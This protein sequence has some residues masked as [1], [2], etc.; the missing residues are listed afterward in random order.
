MRMAA[1]GG[2]L[3]LAPQVCAEGE[4]PV[5]PVQ[6]AQASAPQA[7]ASPVIRPGG[8]Q[9]AAPKEKSGIQNRVNPRRRKGKD[10]SEE[11]RIDADQARELYI[12]RKLR[13]EQIQAQQKELSNNKRTLAANRARMQ[14]RLIET[15]RA[16]R[17][18]E[19]RLTEIEERLAS[20][21]AKVREQREKLDDKSAQ[22][23][24]L[25]VLMQGMSRQPPPLMITHSRDA[26][27]MIRSGMVVA[28]FY[29][30]IEKLATQIA[31]EVSQL[32]ASEKEAELQEQRRKSEQVQNSRL[33]A[34]IDL[35]LIENREQLEA[36]S[37]RADSLSSATKINIASI[38]SLEEM[39]PAL[40]LERA[41]KTN[42]ASQDFGK[43][44]GTEEISPN[45]AK[46]VMIEPGRM[47]PAIPFSNSQGLLPMPAQGKMLIR[48]GQL[49]RD[50]AA[51][52]GVHIETRPAAQIISPCDG[53][54]LYAGPFR[55]Y[56][57]LL[58]IDPGG[59]YHVVVAGMDRIEATK[60]QFVLAGEPVAAMGTETRS[61]DKTP[62]RPIL[63]VEFR[64]D[65]Q[66]ID[67][68]PWWS[69]GGKG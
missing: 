19:K 41:R 25:F 53:L 39:L 56:G 35:L 46:I 18:S 22:M 49:D 61:G 43:M 54:I 45:A 12:R 65:Q 24:A 42:A 38:K 40:D 69:A 52:K 5:K 4:F 60:G 63:Y 7:S 48:F 67:P 15:A 68:A 6:L 21:R 58:I 2:L 8:Q 37:A 1:A 29:G 14:A 9:K 50:G 64:R 3:L 17:L 62:A 66:S 26:L 10:G 20:T 59:G 23:S 28:T 47:Q 11:A 34:Q 13:L 51:S 16:L 55:S 44:N 27:K 31:G 36:A 32:E 33:K 30:D 57:Q